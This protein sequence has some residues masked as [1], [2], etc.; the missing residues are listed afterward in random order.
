MSSVVIQLPDAAVKNYRLKIF[1]D[2]EK[3]VLELTKLKEDFLILD[4]MNFMR[5]GWYRFELYDG[6]KVLEKNRFFV[7]KD[8]KKKNNK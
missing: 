1:D 6:E 7:P 4:K 8:V 3:M 5:S 2:Q